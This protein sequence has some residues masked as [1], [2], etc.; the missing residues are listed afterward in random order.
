V[1]SIKQKIFVGGVKKEAILNLKMEKP[2]VYVPVTV[3]FDASLSQVKDDN[4]V[5]FVYDYGDGVSEE[6]DAINP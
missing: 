4:I 1:M 2:S 5:K 3:R 6:R